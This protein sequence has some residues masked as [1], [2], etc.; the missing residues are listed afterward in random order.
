[1]KKILM[2]VIFCLLL[3]ACSKTVNQIPDELT[4]KELMT[5][6]KTALEENDDFNNTLFESEVDYYQQFFTTSK[7]YHLN[8]DDLINYNVED[9][10]FQGGYLRVSKIL[11]V[12]SELIQI[13]EPL[14]QIEYAFNSY[15]VTFSIENQKLKLHIKQ[16]SIDY[17]GYYQIYLNDSDLL[18]FDALEKSQS[19]IFLTEVIDYIYYSQ[20]D[21]YHELSYIKDGNMQHYFQYDYEYIN[22]TVKTFLVSTMPTYHHYDIARAERY[23]N[24]DY[25]VVYSKG[26][27]YEH[28]YF[29]LFND[30]HTSI[31]INYLIQNP[32]PNHVPRY[33]I[34]WNL[35]DVEGWSYIENDR[36]YTNSTSVSITP[37]RTQDLSYFGP[38]LTLFDSTNDL[39]AFQIN[40]PKGL[41]TYQTYQHTDFTLPLARLDELESLLDANETS[42]TEFGVVKYFSDGFYDR[43]LNFISEENLCQ[44][45]DLT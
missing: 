4:S 17:D 35:L 25:Y 5:L 44:V 15:K 36:V 3:S 2:V 19:D 39:S 32:E 40:Q 16:D 45:V 37:F 6:F 28:K 1:M 7:N 34:Q 43:F 14:D 26:S 9:V 38:E 31:N 8:S 18:V 42:Y 23:F 20:E 10:I 12:L 13:D 24:D 11:D 21:E 30:G 41:F 27:N 22:H 29:S 33:D